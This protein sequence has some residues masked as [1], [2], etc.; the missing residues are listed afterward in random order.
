M[1]TSVTDFGGEHRAPVGLAMTVLPRPER[2]AN[3][4]LGHP[5][6]LCGQHGHRLRIKSC[7]AGQGGTNGHAAHH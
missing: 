1:A 4:R 5:I 2:L 7:P 3:Y 6:R